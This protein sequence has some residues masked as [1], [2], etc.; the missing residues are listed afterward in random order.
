MASRD[1]SPDGPGLVASFATARFEQNARYLPALLEAPDRWLWDAVAGASARSFPFTLA[2]VK[3]SPTTA[4][5]VVHLVGGSDYPVD[6]D[7]HVRVLV[8]G[9]PVAEASWDGLQPRAIEAGFDASLLQEG[10]NTLEVVNVGDTR[11]SNPSSTST[12]SR[13][14]THAGSRRRRGVS[15]PAST[16]PVP[17]RSR[18]SRVPTCWTRARTRPS[19]SP[20]V[21][22]R[23]PGS[24]TR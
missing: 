12:A 11:Q 19:G 10:P 16:P 9:A 24:A 5:I 13:F 20:V 8:N 6:P 15:R 21:G 1:A 23:P 17:R 22:R 4:E 7:H 14:G 3:A 2:D 18:V